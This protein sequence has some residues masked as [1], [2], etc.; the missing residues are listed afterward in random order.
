MENIKKAGSSVGFL[1]NCKSVNS[2]PLKYVEFEVGDGSE[3]FGS[4]CSGLNILSKGERTIE[5][6]VTKHKKRLEIL[7][8]K[9]CLGEGEYLDESYRHN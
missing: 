9:V 6:C 3:I 8:N 7:I 5:R 4:C 2:F 1:V